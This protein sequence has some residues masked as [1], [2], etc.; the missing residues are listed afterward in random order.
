ML[1]TG[2]KEDSSTCEYKL[3]LL[4]IADYLDVAIEEPEVIKRLW[5]KIRELD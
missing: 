3:A 5:D 4:A 2:H 1:S